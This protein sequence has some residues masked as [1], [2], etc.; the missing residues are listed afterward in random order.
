MTSRPPAAMRVEMRLQRLAS[1]ARALG[2]QRLARRRAFVLAAADRAREAVVEAREASGPSTRRR[3]ARGR[4]RGSM[5]ILPA[6]TRASCAQPM[7]VA[8]ARRRYRA[9]RRSALGWQRRHRGR[10]GAAAPGS[11]HRRRRRCARVGVGRPAA[12]DRQRHQ[13]QVE[14]LRHIDRL[15]DVR[16]HVSV[17]GRAEQRLV[18]A[19]RIEAELAAGRIAGVG[20][21]RHVAQPERLQPPQEDADV[22]DVVAPRAALGP[23]HLRACA[24]RR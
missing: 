17:T 4:A 20:R 24:P 10:R 21:Q 22:R 7:H 8:A 13:P 14:R 5:E 23:A 3:A 2:R 11:R 1:A 6:G 15:G 12:R 9:D 19:E 16:D 18:G